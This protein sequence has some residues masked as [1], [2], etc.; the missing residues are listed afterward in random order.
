MAPR[1]AR[2]SLPSAK[3]AATAKSKPTGRKRARIQKRALDAFA[4]A[5]AQGLDKP[6]VRRNRLGQ[7]EGGPSGSMRKRRRGGSDDEDE[8]EDEEE[9]VR[10]RPKKGRFDE[11]DVDEGSDSEGNTWT[12]GQVDSEGDSDIDS[13][14]AFGES[15]EEKFEGWTFR[16]SESQGKA[17]KKKKKVKEV[18]VKGD[19]ELDLNEEADEEES[20]EESLGEDAVDLA[21]MLDTY[22]DS[23][24]EGKKSNGSKKKHDASSE[25]EDDDADDETSDEESDESMSDAAGPDDEDDLARLHSLVETLHPDNKSAKQKFRGVDTHEGRAPSAFGLV[26]EDKFDIRDFVS[27]AADPQVKA[28]SKQVGT[29]HKP[30]K[31]DPKL[32]PS[33]PKRQKDKIDRAVANEKAKETLERWVDTVKHNRKADHLTFPLVD[34]EVA[35]PRGSKHLLPTSTTAPLT[36]L[37]NTIQSILEESGLAK[38]TANKEEDMIREFEELKT[39]KMPLEEVQARR[40]E[41]RKQRELLFREEVRARRI[42]KIK[43]KAFRRVHRKEREK[44]AA[45]DRDAFAADGGDSELD[46]ED[47]ITA[48]RRRAEER[49]G[50]KHR[51]SK[52]AKA[53]KKSGRSVWDE[54]ARSGVTEMARKNEELRRRIEGKEVREGSEGVTSDEDEESGEDSDADQDASLQRQLERVSGSKD[55]GAYSRLG[56][57]DFMKRADAARKTQ[58]D[59]AVERMRRELA[60]EESEEVEEDET[61]G[62]KIFGPRAELKMPLAV[63]P[64]RNEFEEPEG[65]SDVEMD[66]LP[67][68]IEVAPSN[69]APSAVGKAFKKG[70]GKKAEVIAK[71]EQA[72]KPDAP[73]KNQK[74]KGPAV[75]AG[76]AA[77]PEL[78]PGEVHSAPDADGWVTVNYQDEDEAGGNSD[79]ESVLSQREIIRRAFAGDDVEA[80]FEAEKEAAIADEGDKV[81]DDT[82]PGWGN[83]VGEGVSR[84]EKA[85]HKGRVVRTEKGIARENR[86]DAKL[87]NV[88]ISHKRV[89]KNSGYLASTLPFP[90]TNRAEYE[91]SIRMPIGPDWNV[92]ETFQANTK[93]RVLVKPGAVITPMEKPLV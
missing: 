27:T 49:M 36:S 31:K 22:E 8:D 26:S 55:D 82:L 21:T 41:L 63:K 11:L 13:D 73:K 5:S 78:L 62:R 17:V 60:G 56:A 29:L 40:A 43:S 1:I 93:P 80:D 42:K 77:E 34:P 3:P 59:E 7:A 23:E 67:A 37:E 51:D 75:K 61:I 20:D 15:D 38:S 25:S 65:S 28:V 50:A 9:E 39:N 30:L 18:E 84:R 83:W 44:L 24:D 57:L 89:K 81:I 74:A 70:K 53:M 47:R 2:S 33:L 87:K 88:I 69:P 86:K 64:T 46:E 14:E 54:D 91:R 12:M 79:A 32:E 10:T 52:W 71:P 66:D 16:G 6:K 35:Q 90:F 85:K 92:K 48:D 58:N 4:I 68:M 76:K 19:E 72:K 45:M